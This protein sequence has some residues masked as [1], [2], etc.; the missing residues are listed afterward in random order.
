MHIC[1]ICKLVSKGVSEVKIQPVSSKTQVVVYVNVFNIM[2][3]NTT[4]ILWR[5]VKLSCTKHQ[6]KFV[7]GS[8]VY[9]TS[10]YI[11]RSYMHVG[12]MCEAKVRHVWSIT[13][14]L[15]V[16]LSVIHRV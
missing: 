8:C 10:K 3:D 9:T 7:S 12:G 11:I 6:Q 1:V 5:I 14:V 2:F 15:G 16:C 4:R 13:G